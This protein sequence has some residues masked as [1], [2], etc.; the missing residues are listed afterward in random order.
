MIRRSSGGPSIGFDDFLFSVCL[1]FIL[2]LLL[3][4]YAFQPKVLDLCSW[5]RSNFPPQRHKI[6]CGSFFNVFSFPSQPEF[7]CRCLAGRIRPWHSPLCACVGIFREK[8]AKDAAPST[9]FHN[10]KWTERQDV[11]DMFS[12]NRMA[13]QVVFKEGEKYKKKDTV[14]GGKRAARNRIDGVTARILLCRGW[15]GGWEPGEPADFERA[16]R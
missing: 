8:G 16:F 11:D 1:L 12:F 13:D 6:E 10:I 5:K 7:V 9:H 14:V 2:L 15:N 4:F 3:S